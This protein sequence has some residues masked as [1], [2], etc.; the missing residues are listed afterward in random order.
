MRYVTFLL[1][2]LC[3]SAWG[4]E[5]PKGDTYY[6][7]FNTVAPSTGAP[8]TIGG[9]PA[10]EVYE[11]GSDTQITAGTTLD[12]DTDSVTGL[13]EVAIDTSNAA[14]E[15]GKWYTAVVAGT[16]PTADSVSILG[17]SVA[18][19]RIVAA[20]NVAGVP[21]VDIEYVGGADE[22]TELA[23]D[24]SVATA[25]ETEIND[26]LP[27]AT[28]TTNINTAF[29]DTLAEVSGV[30]SAT[31]PLW[32][33]VGFLF[34]ALTAGYENTSSNG[35]EKRY[36]NAAGTTQWEKDLTNDGTTYAESAAGA[37]D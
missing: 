19:F 14:Y 10:I 31:D 13:H 21:V 29:A 34:Q 8:V 33:K 2:L 28:A 7:H 26:R 4:H 17:R 36:K 27:N 6:F 15:A 24:A 18:H 23:T 35:G 20:E 9:T 11:D 30:P 22:A 3:G 5:V 25:V 16:T 32:E 37:P 1:L 12:A